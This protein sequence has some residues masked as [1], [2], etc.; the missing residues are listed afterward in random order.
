[1]SST[2]K[3][4]KFIHSENEIINFFNFIKKDKRIKQIDSD[5]LYIVQILARRKYNPS[6]KNSQRQIINNLHRIET[7]EKLVNSLYRLEVKEGLYQSLNDNNETMNLTSEMLAL[8]ITCNSINTLRASRKVIT[9]INTALFDFAVNEND[10][11]LQ[12]RCGR[13]DKLYKSST[14]Q[15]C[16]YDYIHFDIDIADKYNENK[17]IP[18]ALSELRIFLKYVD[19]KAP[20][21]KKYLIETTNG[22]HLLINVIS[23]NDKPII[24]VFTR[25]I[26]HMKENKKINSSLQP[27]YKYWNIDITN[28]GAPCPIPGTYQG[29][30]PVIS[31]NFNEYT[32]VSAG[33][34]A[35]S[36]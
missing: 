17:L 4:Y 6:L 35:D 15:S 30:F 25:M 18:E 23:S 8:Y 29:G 12:Y 16:N 13:I 11:E 21:H 10:T 19:C 33:I 26:N 5:K 32:H 28:K 20:N 36:I 27:N 3:Y 7:G 31:H 2:S 9:D 14:Q 34:S 24:G 22:F 1:M